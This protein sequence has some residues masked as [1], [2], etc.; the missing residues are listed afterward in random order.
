VRIAAIAAVASG[1]MPGTAGAA[2]AQQLPPSVLAAL[3]QAGVPG[4]AMAAVVVEAGNGALP[5]LAFQ[6][7]VPFNPA[8]LMKLATSAAALELL[9]A[10]YTWTTPVYFGG[11]VRDGRLDGSLTLQGRGDPKL[12]TERLWLLLRRVQQAG[13]RDIAGD[14]VL[15]RSAFQVPAVDPGA[16]DGEPYRPYNVQPDALLFNFKAVMLQL[17]PDV[18]RGVAAVSVDPPL[19]GL[20]VPASVPLTEGA[21]GAGCW[22]VTSLRPAARS[23][24]RWRSPTRAASTPACSRPPGATWAGACAAVCARALR[25]T[26]APRRPSNS[27]RR[28]WPKSSVT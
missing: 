18:A 4:E 21:C 3:A 12:V 6:A 28:R 14:I 7:E 27:S 17:R 24:G 16:F 2:G 26:T 5:R 13:V 15:D 8:S 23:N 25:L 10:T 9:G 1:L 22:A 20:Q 11:P 19:A